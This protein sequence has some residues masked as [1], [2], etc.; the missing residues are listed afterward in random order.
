MPARRPPPTGSER[1]AHGGGDVPPTA[2]EEK[3]RLLG[4]MVRLVARGVSNGL[5]VAGQ[6]GLGKSLTI[7]RT[8][9]AEG[10]LP[11]LINSHIT[12]LSLYATLFHNRQ[13]QMIW[14]DDCD[15][16]YQNLAV[17][18]LLRSALWGLGER[19]VT[20]TSTRL[21]GLPARFA[22]DSRIIACAN[23]FP[24][25][26][27]AF[28]AVLS[29]VDV[30]ELAATNDEVVELMRAMAAGAHGSLTPERCLEVVEF[31]ARAGGSRQLSMRLYEPSL[32]KVEYAVQ[33]RVPWRE[34]VRSQLDQIGAD[35]GVPRPP[36][37]RG[38]D[39]RA[40]AQ[41]AAAHP[42]SV[43]MQ[44]EAWCEDTGKSRATFYWVKREYERQSGG[45]GG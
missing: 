7:S 33:N 39:L 4:H 6:G 45:G 8:L 29:R 25:R 37:A 23:T 36:D 26:N 30:F 15:S 11:V 18:G 5:F 20:Y 24:R 43:K 3:Q 35:D 34:L 27:E 21:D 16:V 9:A 31:I 10:V 12:P 13:G 14:L 40:M 19:V 44:E 2:L 22:F 17:L 1:P 28:R 32:R 42:A 41:A 38:H